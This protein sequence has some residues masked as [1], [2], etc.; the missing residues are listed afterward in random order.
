[1]NY[2]IRH[3]AEILGGTFIQFAADTPVEHLLLD[4]RR[5]IFPDTTI[6]FSLKG[7]RRDGRAFLEELYI[8][9]VRNFVVQDRDGLG[10]RSAG[11]GE[12]TGDGQDS[13]GIGAHEPG[14]QRGAEMGKPIL[15]W[16]PIRWQLCSNWQPGI[17]DSFRFP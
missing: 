9:G 8:R 16:C 4:S 17:E 5:L 2:T 1:M 7:P 3:I 11:Q 10:D 14:D 6:F 15:S 13:G 12:G